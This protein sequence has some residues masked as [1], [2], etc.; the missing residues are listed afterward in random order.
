MEATKWATLL[1]N[2]LHQLKETQM[3]NTSMLLINDT[4]RVTFQHKIK[5]PQLCT[6]LCT[7][8]SAKASRV[9]GS[10]WNEIFLTEAP[11]KLSFQSIAI[12]PTLP[13]ESLK[14]AASQLIFMIKYSSFFH[15]MHCC[16]LRLELTSW[17]LYFFQGSWRLFQIVLIGVTLMFNQQTLVLCIWVLTYSSWQ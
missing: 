4:F 10:F 11:T 9:R 6:Q 13:S 7:F 5:K 17:W 15:L 16:E 2:I 1:A 12:H 3:I 14:I 8:Q